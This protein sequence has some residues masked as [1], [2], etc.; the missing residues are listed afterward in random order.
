MWQGHGEIQAEGSCS[1][2]GTPFPQPS[3]EFRQAQSIGTYPLMVTLACKS[4]LCRCTCWKQWSCRTKSVL[5]FLRKG[6]SAGYCKPYV[7]LGARPWKAC[8]VHLNVRAF[9]PSCS[10]LAFSGSSSLYSSSISWILLILSTRCLPAPLHLLL[11]C[12]AP[13][14]LVPLLLYCLLFLFHF[15]LLIFEPILWSIFHI[16]S[17]FVFFLQFRGDFLLSDLCR[18]APAALYLGLVVE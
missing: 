3:W 12:P 10:L 8:W 18:S 7:S 13:A 5:C 17:F 14:L 15:P 9:I 16:C 11:Q 1:K 2:F 6:G 4:D